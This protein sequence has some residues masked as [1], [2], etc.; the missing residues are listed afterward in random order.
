MNWVFDENS[1]IYR[2]I[3]QMIKNEILNGTLAPGSKIMSTNEYATFYNVNPATV[4]K[5]FRELVETGIL[6]KQRGIGMF[7][8]EDAHERMSFEFRTRF[9]T[10]VLDP[11]V[12][13]A[14]QAGIPLEA[15]IRYL[16]SKEDESP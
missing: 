4:Q 9:F 15:V 7:V 3:A 16:R 1:P 8:A 14:R 2:Q 6:Y 11:I 5:A 13:Q 10:E 12:D